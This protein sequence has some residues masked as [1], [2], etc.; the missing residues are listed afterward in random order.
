MLTIAMERANRFDRTIKARNIRECL[1][2]ALVTVFFAFVAWKSP[3][4]LVR[5]GNILIAASGAW[6]IFYMLRFGREAPA[7]QP[8]QSLADFQQALLRKYDHQIRL[9]KNVK[10]W[11]LLPMYVGLILVDAGRISERVAEGRAGWVDAI[12]PAIYTLVFAVIWW[13]NEVNAAGRLREASRLFSRSRF[14]LRT[15]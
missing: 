14:T 11:Y 7:P 6:I 9:L 4:A 5:A 15:G 12:G 10:Y 2:A 1:A 3:D 13:L 8:D